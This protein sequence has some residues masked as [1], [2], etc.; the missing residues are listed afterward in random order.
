[1]SAWKRKI[2]SS[3]KEN[4]E[5]VGLSAN[6]ASIAT[7][8][9]NNMP[10]VR[11]VVMRDFAG[12]HHTDNTGWN[13]DLLV[14]ITDKR[15]DKINELKQN[16]NIELNWYMN[17]TMEQFRV[18]GKVDIIEKN[19]DNKKLEHL[20]SHFE[21]VQT[22]EYDHKTERLRHFYQFGTHMRAQ[23]TND[24]SKPLDINEINPKDGWFK[25]DQVQDSLE[26]AFE[27]FVLLVI[28]V[29]SVRHWSPCT[30]TKSLL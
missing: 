19:Y 7:V 29:T 20:G 30:G 24:P 13:S 6:Y 5:K 1:M 11:T 27:N 23:M 14:I 2:Q 9:P 3:L 4:I 18:A 28:T 21:Q 17:S 8:K 25:N 15:S 26:E 16:P 12:E 10:A 22:G